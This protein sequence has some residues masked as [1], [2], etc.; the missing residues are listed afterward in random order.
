MLNELGDIYQKME[1]GIR[2]TI[3]SLA[4]WHYYCVSVFVY[5]YIIFQ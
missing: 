1:R 2:Y 3:V 5:V 4:A